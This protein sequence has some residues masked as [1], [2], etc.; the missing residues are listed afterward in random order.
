M[1]REIRR[2]PIDWE[3]PKDEHGQYR[4]MF[5]TMHQQAVAAW[6]DD[7]YAFIHD[8]VEQAEAKEAGCTSFT[9]WHGARPEDDGYY[10]PD[11]PEGAATAYQVYETVTK[12]T[13]ASPV[14]NSEADLRVWLIAQGHSEYA[15]DKFI[16]MKWAPSMIM[17]RSGMVMGIDALNEVLG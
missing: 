11:W 15:A 3:H 12:G 10:R 7:R 5:G 4:P 1:G 2:V 9:D 17:T 14:F 13:P 6:N 16:E 8:P